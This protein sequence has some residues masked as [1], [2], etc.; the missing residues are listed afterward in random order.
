VLAAPHPISSPIAVV[1]F[2]PHPTGSLNRVPR[3]QEA[4]LM[5]AVRLALLVL[6]FAAPPAFAQV[7]NISSNVAVNTTWGPTGTVVG[8]IF[9]I[10]NSINVNGGVTLTIQPGVIV[11]FN[12]STSLTVLGTLNANGTSGSNIFFTSIKDDGVGGDTNGDGNAT[13]PAPQDWGSITFPSSAPG[14]SVLNY[15]DIRYGGYSQGGIL[16]F[17]SS[18]QSVTNS[19]IRRGYFGIDCQGTAAPTI[20]GTTIEAS[21]VTPIVLDFTAAPVFSSLVFSSA[22]NGYDAFGLRGATLLNGTTATLPKRGAT[23]G[24]NTISN[25]TYV[26]LGTLTINS[27]ASLTINPGVVIKPTS[28]FNI[29]VL[30]N[31]TMNGTSAVGDTISITSISDDN[32]GQPPDTNNNGSITAPA[33][34]NWGYVYYQAGSTGSVSYSR[35]RFGSNS[36]TVGEV[37]T[38]NVTIPVSNSLLTDASHGLA[39]LGTG[40]P[41]ITNVAIN[42]C[43]ST[44]ILLSVSANPSF[45]GV[46]FLANALTALGLEGEIVAV[47][48]HIFFRNVAGYTNITYYLMNGSLEMASPAIL[49][50]DPGVV[51]KNQISGGGIIIDGGLIANGTVSQPI[52][53]TSERDDAYGNPPD[54]NGDGS[55]T[56]PAS[57]NWTYIR[58]TGTSNDGVDVMNYCRVLYASYGPFDGWNTALWVTSA[59]PTITHC[60]FSKATYAIRIEGDSTPTIDFCDFNNLGAAPYA[61]SVQSDPNIG[62]NSTYSTNGYN[63][64]ALISGTMS[65][66]ARIKYRP[67]VGSPTFAY[68][69]TGTITIPSGVTLAIDPQVVLKPTSSFTL[70]QVNGALNVVGSNNTTGRVVFTSR[71]DDN[72]AYGG[73]TT[74]TDASAP[75][76]GDWG[77][78]NFSDTAVDAQCVL[79][80]VLFQFGGAGGNDNGTITTTSASPR[81]VNLEFFSNYTAM[82]FG[83]NSTPVVDTTTIRNCVYLPIVFSLISDP[84]FPNPG[85]ITLAN[86]A[87]TCL[88]LL[89]ETVAQD[90]HTVVRNI[91]TYT[92]ISYCPA[93]TI[94]IAF[95]AK[96]TIDPGVVIKLGRVGSDP[97]GSSINIDGA[98]VANGTIP[99]PI[100]FTS[101]ADDTYGTDIRSDGALTAPAAGQ[102]FGIT[103]SAI[104]NDLVT[105]INNCKFRYAGYN[106]TGALR[107]VNAGPTVTN[108]TIS[109]TSGIGVSIEGNSTPTFSSCT[110]DNSTNVPVNMSLVSEPVFT[111]LTFTNNAYTALGVIGESIAQD[112]LWKIRPVSGRNNMPYLLQSQLTIG[113]GAALTMQPGVIVKNNGSGSIFVQRAMI[114]EGRAFR[115]ESLIVFTSYRDDAYGGDTNGDG[116]TTP[117]AAGDWNYITIDGTAIDA[118]CRFKNCLF[119]YG[120]SGTTLGALRA[121]NSSP[122]ADSCL[123]AYNSVGISV[124]GASNPTA[125]GCSFI[126]NTQFAINNTGNSFCVNAENSWWGATNGPN[127][128]SATADLCGLGLNAGSGDKVSNNVDYSPY[129]TSGI[130]N[131]LLG[132]VSL[133]GVVRAYDASLILQKLAALITLNPL[134]TIVADVSGDGSVSSLDASLILQWVAGSI[135]AFPAASNRAQ[136]ATPD[137][138]AAREIVRRAAGTF[139]FQLGEPVRA[140]AVW[141][142]PVRVTGTAPI[143]GF[144]FHVEGGS[145]AALVAVEASFEAWHNVVGDQ[146]LVAAASATPVPQGEVAVLSFDA[147]SGSWSPPR[148]AFAR[149]NETVVTGGSTPP[150][151]P[152]AAFFAPPAPNP[153]RGPASLTLGISSAEAGAA[154]SVRVLDLAGRT[155]RTL[156]RGALPAGVH[157]FTWDLRDDAG[158]GVR[159][160][161]YFI[162]ARAGRLDVT[163]RLIVVR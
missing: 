1:D 127:D 155:V 158:N 150:A 97:I 28:G 14:T 104:S 82:T 31:L 128:A 120:G 161:L 73:D 37:T 56:V 92:N 69:P 117:P 42:N 57:G 129:A 133:N 147:S 153:A 101:S 33:P 2:S 162:H 9:R 27:G 63:A 18:S 148:L 114:A 26:L 115:A 112:V 111:N 46:S 98:L 80:N 145:A 25:V 110:I 131:P 64:I 53:L 124:E 43:T 62:V 103:F 138:V 75:Q 40:T 34:G 8:T 19:V 61:M 72:P 45:S 39:I 121:V 54:T 67:G 78:I 17:Q 85:Q 99:S 30:G 3:V 94:G 146:A 41:S 36:T 93:G 106:G 59:A 21:I 109:F 20:S 105:V 66:N 22:N 91:G 137:V 5:R 52:V 88:G 44:P 113:L 135:L 107:F 71:R 12:A 160:G 90:V 87:Y 74:P 126:G 118:Q 130:L 29:N 55:S 157:P 38:Q 10:T 123:F 58:F 159:P 144:D 60:T 134:Q 7:V 65:A 81:L 89:D 152:A 49:T 136:E 84:Q 11:K 48:S 16:V 140:G 35:L 143:Y 24:L 154:A 100:V 79:R 15:C 50:I 122:S 77:S 119:R 32:L 6:V 47:D 13:V 68:L 95:G 83:G 149:V 102:W 23:I 4:L 139:D 96:W 141:K 70:F 156:V 108:T 86:N 125:R 116:A 76:S 151:M 132:D 142:V 51:I 163:H